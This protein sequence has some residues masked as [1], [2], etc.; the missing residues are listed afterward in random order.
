MLRQIIP[1]IFLFIASQLKHGKSS[2]GISYIRELLFYYAFF[3]NGQTRFTHV[4][5][6]QKQLL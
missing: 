3:C 4:N 6:L 5:K 2:I 1:T